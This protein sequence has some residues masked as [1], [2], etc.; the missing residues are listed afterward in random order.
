MRLVNTVLPILQSRREVMRV[1]IC[2][3][4]G[5][6]KSTLGSRLAKSSDFQVLDLDEEI[7]ERMGAGYDSLSDYI[8][9][10][11]IDEFRKDEQEMIKLLHGNFKDDYVI[12][13]GGGSLEST[14]VVD[15]IKSVEA[16]VVFLDT[17]F[18]ECYSRLKKDGNRPL[19]KKGRDF[20]KAKFDER[21]SLYEGISSLKLSPE[22]SDEISSL[23][24][25]IGLL[26]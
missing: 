17:P 6:G 15:F 25:L 24:D 21:A 26:K 1:F 3:F 8:E 12:I 14:L 18:D 5:S 22:Q 16:R 7:Y 9:D 13:L 19:M 10:I 4:S 23:S 20:M 2:G 11:G